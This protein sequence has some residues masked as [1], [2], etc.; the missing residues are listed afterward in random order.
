MLPHGNVWRVADNKDLLFPD[1]TVTPTSADREKGGIALSDPS[2]GIDVDDW[3]SSYDSNTGIFSLKNKRTLISYPVLTIPDAVK[4]SFAF[5]ANM[6]PSVA[7]TDSL[8]SAKFY[9]YD[10]VPE[11][12]TTTTLPAGTKTPVVCHDQKLSFFTILNVTDV[13]LFYIKSNNTLVWRIQRE[14]YN[15]E[16]YVCDVSADAQL[17]K[18]GMGTD[19]RLKIVFSSGTADL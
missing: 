15:T 5:D 3:E 18:V 4:I 8:G 10:S 6:R 17:L 11:D 16:H 14:R 2:A 13:I 9:W 19:N 7:W 12:Y 1:S